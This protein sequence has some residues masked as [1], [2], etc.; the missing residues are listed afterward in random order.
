MKNLDVSPVTAL[1][2]VAQDGPSMLVVDQLDAVSLAS[3]RMPANFET[4]TDLAREARAFPGMR[5]V[6]ACRKFDVDNDHRIRALAA[7]KEVIQVEVGLL[8]REQVDTAV[9]AMGL[10]AD[11]LTDGQRELLMTPLHLVLLRSVADQPD[12]LSFA[13]ETQ[14]FDAY[15]N[16]KRYDCREQRPQT[17]PR[18]A[19][20]IAVLVEAMSERQRLSAPASVLDEGDLGSDADAL[21]SQGVLVPDGSELAFFHEGFFDYAFARRWLAERQTLVEFLHS[22]EQELFRR[23]RCRQILIRLH[24]DDPERFISEVEAVLTDPDTRFHIKDTVLAVLRALTEPTAPDWELMR[25][26]TAAEL[27]VTDRLWLT[28]RTL[29]WF[30]RLDAEGVIAGGLASPNSADHRRVLELMLGAVKER[31]DRMAELLAPYAGRA[32]DYPAWLSWVIRF[33][34]IYESRAL[35]ELVTGAVRRG[36]FQGIEGALW[37]GTHGLGQHQPGWAAELLGAYLAG[38]PHAFDLDAVGRVAALEL[39]EHALIELTAQSTE[40]APREFLELLVPYLLRVMGLTGTQSAG[41]PMV[42]RYFSSRTHPVDGLAYDLGDALL[43]GTAA[44]LRKLVEAGPKQPGPFWRS[45]RPTRTRARSGSCTT[46]SGWRG[47]TTRTGPRPCCWR[48][49]TGS[50]AGTRRTRSGGLGCS[51]RP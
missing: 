41:L 20:V 24:G 18:F 9:L 19:Q 36:D 45:S 15:W 34:N 27:P 22:S 26:L 25:R 3:G 43:Q 8:T 2:A 13:T 47:S 29:P 21:I 31:P 39:R 7:A 49:T 48:A 38:R 14:L 6:L 46:H 35:F 44:A 1:A 33:G 11:H 30:E 51:L 50:S 4:I 10:P 23:T 37:L 42:D 40:G 12:A 17:P 16:R 28:M 32:P 5:V